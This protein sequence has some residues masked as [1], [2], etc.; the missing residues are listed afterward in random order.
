MPHLNLKYI[1]CVSLY[2]KEMQPTSIFMPGELHVQRSLVGY[3]PWGR[4]ESEK[5]EHLSSHTHI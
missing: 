4:K 1:L 2:L 5:I 3:G